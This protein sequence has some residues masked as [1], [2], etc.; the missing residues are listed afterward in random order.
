M[1]AIVTTD[2]GH[3]TLPFFTQSVSSFCGHP[4][5]IK[6]AKFPFIV[7]FNE[8]PAAGS[9]ERD[10]QSPRRCHKKS[11]GEILNKHI[12]KHKI[13]ILEKRQN[14]WRKT[15]QGCELQSCFRNSKRQ[16]QGSH[17]S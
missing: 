15:S 10:V 2:L 14:F 12:N 1:S 8:L 5:L 17:P 3:R 6:D 9:L 11:E 4:L 7:H 16:E 13:R